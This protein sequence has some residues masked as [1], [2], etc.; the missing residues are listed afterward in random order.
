MKLQKIDTLSEF[1]ANLIPTKL[2]NMS[3]TPQP[4]AAPIMAPVFTFVQQETW[5]AAD[6][7]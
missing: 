5:L 1:S 6:W 7:C 3:P 2:P 4:S